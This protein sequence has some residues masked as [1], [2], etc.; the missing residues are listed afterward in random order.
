MGTSYTNKVKSLTRSRNCIMM[1]LEYKNYVIAAVLLL[2]ASGVL[3]VMCCK[4][5]FKKDSP[6]SFHYEHTGK[7]QEGI[8]D[9]QNASGK[10]F[11]T[12]ADRNY[13]T[14]KCGS[15]QHEADLV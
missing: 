14:R 10:W 9:R 6:V 7:T 8:L 2:V 15:W 4:S 12:W 3:Y 11:V 1:L 5:G 13:P